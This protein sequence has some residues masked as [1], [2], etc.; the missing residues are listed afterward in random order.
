MF[1]DF[2]KVDFQSCNEKAVLKAIL[3]KGNLAHSASVNMETGSEMGIDYAK[4]DIEPPENKV[5]KTWITDDGKLLI[6]S[7][8]DDTT[9][10]ELYPFDAEKTDQEG[11]A[12]AE[13]EMR[14]RAGWWS[15]LNSDQ[16]E[17]FVTYGNEIDRV[18][19]D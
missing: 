2:L 19:I 14:H 9:M 8:P 12:V 6:P 1:S 18:V 13:A 5:Y 15:F 3:V 17:T 10:N 7:S 4:Q 11:E 16:T